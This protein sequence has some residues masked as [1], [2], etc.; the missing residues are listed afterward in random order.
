VDQ[1]GLKTLAIEIMAE[2][3]LPLF[4]D[5]YF[6]SIFLAQVISFWLPNYNW[7]VDWTIKKSQSLTW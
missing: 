6:Y 1:L 7:C 4:N 2:I 3:K 5:P